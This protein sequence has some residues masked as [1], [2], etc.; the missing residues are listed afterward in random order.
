M[1]DKPR[2]S[3]AG[4]LATAYVS[5]TELDIRSGVDCVVWNDGG[6]G[7]VALFTSALPCSNMRSRTIR[8]T[9]DIECRLVVAVLLFANAARGVSGNHTLADSNLDVCIRRA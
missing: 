9:A 6:F 3:L 1:V 2:N 4:D 7:V 8:G 5:A